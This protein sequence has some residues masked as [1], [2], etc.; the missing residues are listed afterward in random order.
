M[1]AC[2]DFYFVL[3]LPLFHLSLSPPELPAGAPISK[4][5][6]ASVAAKA[7]LQQWLRKS[8]LSLK[9]EKRSATLKWPLR[10][11]LAAADEHAKI[12]NA[13]RPVYH[14]E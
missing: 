3:P 7:S 4:V 2:S 8:A 1:V 11:M 6:H 9:K 13:R 5:L 14:Q 10:R 12:S